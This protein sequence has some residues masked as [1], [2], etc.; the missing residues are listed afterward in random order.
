MKKISFYK[1]PE[2]NKGLLTLI[3][4][5]KHVIKN[6]MVNVGLKLGFK[7]IDY[8]Y[9]HGEARKLKL[10]LN[11]STM[12]ATFNVIC[13]D[14]TIGDNTIFGHE[15]MVLTG[16]HQFHNGIRMSLLG[17]SNEVP[18]T[19]GDIVI[20]SGCFIGSRSI[21]LKGSKIGDNVIIGAGSVVC[22]EI[23]DGVFAA[24]IPAR[25]IKKL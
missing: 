23:P 25:V 8:Y 5:V 21:I 22:G 24:G 2:R 3:A 10:G 11:C 7:N 18:S 14:I 15:C 12:D 20:G 4:R 13:G 6:S 16:Y 1:N 19:G 17:Q 9:I